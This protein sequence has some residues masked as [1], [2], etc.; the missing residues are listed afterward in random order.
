MREQA[1]KILDKVKEKY[2]DL[3]ICELFDDEMLEWVDSDWEEEY[4]SEYDWYIDHNNKEA[5]DVIFKRIIEEIHP[6]LECENTD[7]FILCEEMINEYC[8]YTVQFS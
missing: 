1:E 6:N 3:E 5:E 4:D 2:T 7:L 8:N